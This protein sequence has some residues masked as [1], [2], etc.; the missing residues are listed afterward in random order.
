MKI[1]N[2]EGDNNN[3][4]DQGGGGISFTSEKCLFDPILEDPKCK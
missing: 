2:G 4:I 3:V 1:W